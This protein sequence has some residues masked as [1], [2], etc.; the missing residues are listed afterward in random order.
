M[1]TVREDNLIRENVIEIIWIGGLDS[2]QPSRNVYNC[3]PELSTDRRGAW[4]LASVSI[5]CI[6]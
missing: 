1:E 5:G 2:L 3:V 4:S 6:I